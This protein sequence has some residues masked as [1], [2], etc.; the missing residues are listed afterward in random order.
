MKA[1]AFIL[2]R[3]KRLGGIA[4]GLVTVLVA[5]GAAL[6]A[7]GGGG[8]INGCYA[9][10]DG[11]LR[12][13][14][15]TAQCK[16]GEAALNWN[17]AGP[18]GPQG[19]PGAQGPKGDAGPQGPSGPQGPQGPKGDTGPQG[20]PGPSWSPGYVNVH[21]DRIEP[22]PF[23]NATATVTCPSGKRVLGGGYTSWNVTVS[24]SRPSPFNSSGAWEI[25]A[26]AGAL[27]GWLFPYAICGN[28]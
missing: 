3:K 7:I 25:R 28:A 17:V 2:G 22:G 20:P 8:T 14:D 9:K 19:N 10:R 24:T 6:A 1:L 15:P 26:D 18:Q 11:S 23:G 13:I 12:V 21:G 5:G 27:G 16:S 4:V